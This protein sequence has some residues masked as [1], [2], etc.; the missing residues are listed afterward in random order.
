M[1]T[2]EPYSILLLWR[3]GKIA[4]AQ[5]ETKTVIRDDSGQALVERINPAEEIPL[6]LGAEILGQVNAGLLARIG[7]LETTRTSDIEAAIQAVRTAYDAEIAAL[8]AQITALSAP[9]SPATTAFRSL[10][11]EIQDQFEDSYETAALLI[12][13]GRPDLAILHIQSLTIPANLEP[14]RTQIVALLSPSQS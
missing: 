13:A 9:P 14:Y 4:A 11:K 8:Q 12:Q 2:T 6:D 1:T 3:D 7:E 5:R 10:P